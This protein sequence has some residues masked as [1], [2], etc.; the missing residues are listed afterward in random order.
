MVLNRCISSYVFRIIF[1]SF[2]LLYH[3]NPVS[4]VSPVS[5]VYMYS[6]YPLFPC[7]LHVFPVAPVSPVFPVDE[8][9]TMKFCERFQVIMFKFVS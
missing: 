5:A 6:L 4:R 3:C 8:S 7:I 2:Y 1:H 9:S